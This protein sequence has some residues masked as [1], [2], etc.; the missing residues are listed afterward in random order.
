MSPISEKELSGFP[1][2][3]IKT[4]FVIPENY[5]EELPTRLLHMIKSTEEKELI[6]FNSKNNIY[7]IPEGYFDLFP[8]KILREVIQTPIREKKIKDIP[9]N[10][11][12][13]PNDYFHHFE[14]Q[15]L[16]NLA[17]QE[18]EAEAHEPE[19]SPLL[20]SLKNKHAFS[21]PQGYFHKDLPLLEEKEIRNIN[22]KPRKRNKNLISILAAAAAITFIILLFFLQ[23]KSDKTHETSYAI[24]YL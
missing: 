18:S 3:K 16:Q 21:V 2:V 19:L 17:I 7:N 23:L 4:S 5:F 15:L 10:P 14:K 20:N 13:I 1:S 6:S 11:F 8:E 9:N 12:T 22:F 24:S